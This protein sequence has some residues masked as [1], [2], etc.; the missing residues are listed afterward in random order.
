M[1]FES[2]ALAIFWAMGFR[3][4]ISPSIV[5]F[6]LNGLENRV[7]SGEVNL[8]IATLHKAEFGFFGVMVKKSLKI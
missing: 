5:N 6:A 1:N 8:T 3:S 2:P 4:V 7:T